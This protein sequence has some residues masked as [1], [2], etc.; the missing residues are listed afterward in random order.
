MICL[1]CLKHPT[2][3]CLP[4]MFI[5]V[6]EVVGKIFMSSDILQIAKLH[7]WGQCGRVS[8]G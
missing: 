2:L 3:L 5:E 4:V 6:G 1:I 8:T 7:L